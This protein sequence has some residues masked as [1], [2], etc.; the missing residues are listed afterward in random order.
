MFEVGNLVTIKKA[1]QYDRKTVI[2]TEEIGEII[3]EAER[4]GGPKRWVVA[5]N[6][7]VDEEGVT[8]LLWLRADQMDL[9]QI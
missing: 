2:D 7:I 9:H 4:D 6:D 3:E 8:P 5:M 1:D